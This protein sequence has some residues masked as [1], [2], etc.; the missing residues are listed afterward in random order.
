[1]AHRIVRDAE[2]RTNNVTI[3]PLFIGTNVLI[4]IVS[5]IYELTH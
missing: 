2:A 3:S 5:L 4:L 1:M